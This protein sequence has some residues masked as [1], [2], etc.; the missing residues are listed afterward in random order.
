MTSLPYTLQ[1]LLYFLAGYATAWLT[2]WSLRFSQ[3][4][5]DAARRLL[6]RKARL[7]WKKQHVRNI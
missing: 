3:W 7:K 5:K 4:E 6:L 1:I 2:V